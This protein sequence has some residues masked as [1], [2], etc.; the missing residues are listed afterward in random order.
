VIDEIIA[1]AAEAGA[2][3]SKALGASGGGCV[4]VIAKRD[5]VDA[6]RNA[7]APLGEMLSYSIDQTGVERCR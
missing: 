7:I 5:R 3:G 4:L 6:V 2:I 1:K